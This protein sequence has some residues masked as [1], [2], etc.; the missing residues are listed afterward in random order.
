MWAKLILL[1]TGSMI[2]S[3]EYGNYPSGSIQKKNLLT[4]WGLFSFLRTLFHGDGF[5]T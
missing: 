2:A 1:K 5:V 3:Y 4:I